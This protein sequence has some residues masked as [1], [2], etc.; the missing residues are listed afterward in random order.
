M[1]VGGEFTISDLNFH[2]PTSAVGF[3]ICQGERAGIV[4]MKE[5]AIKL[6]EIAP[7]CKHEPGAPQINGPNFHWRC[8][9][10]IQNAKHH[11]N[12]RR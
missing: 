1:I 12:I 4:R 5:T 7:S 6:Q 9:V 3:G 2:S 8:K 11:A 10:Q